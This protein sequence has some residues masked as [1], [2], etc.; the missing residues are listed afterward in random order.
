MSDLPDYSEFASAPAGEA[1]LASIV[2]MVEEAHAAELAVAEAEEALR[3]KKEALRDVVERRLPEALDAIGMDRLSA[4]GLTV[5]V[6]D[7]LQVSQP[8]VAQ[9]PA[10]YRWLEE[11]GE[12][13][14]VKREVRVTFA[15]GEQDDAEKLESELDADF[16]GRVRKAEEVNTS[17]LKAYLRRA[18]EAGERVP[19]ELFGARAFRVARIRQK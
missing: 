7:A 18:L 17:T 16:P 8:P 6:E 19:L 10:A 15:A 13:G 1:S 4:R 9:R 12:G 14:M 5:T 3:V 11:H 2:A